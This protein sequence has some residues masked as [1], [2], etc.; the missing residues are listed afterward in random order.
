MAGGLN[1]FFALVFTHEDLTSWP[2]LNEDSSFPDMPP[3]HIRPHGVKQLLKLLAYQLA[4]A[5]TLLYQASL[6]QGQLPED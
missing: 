1:N 3:I 4:P 6:V 2:Y 5:L